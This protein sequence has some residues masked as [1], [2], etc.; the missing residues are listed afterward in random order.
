MYPDVSRRVVVGDTVELHEAGGNLV[1]R[2]R[3]QKMI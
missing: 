2:K 3:V 1:Q